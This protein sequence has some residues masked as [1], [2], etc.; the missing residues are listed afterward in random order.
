MCIASLILLKNFK[1]L[2]ASHIGIQQV[3]FIKDPLLSL[4]KEIIK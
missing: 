1:N 4:F 3:R 2:P